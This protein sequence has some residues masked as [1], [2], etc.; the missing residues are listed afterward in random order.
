MQAR[1]AADC[2][3]GSRR[4]AGGYLSGASPPPPPKPLS[5]SLPHICQNRRT[6]KAGLSR[7]PPARSRPGF[8]PCHTVLNT[9]DRNGTLHIQAILSA[10][11]PFAR[12][13]WWTAAAARYRPLPSHTTRSPSPSDF[14]SRIRLRTSHSCRGIWK[15]RLAPWSV[16]NVIRLP[17]SLSLPLSLSVF[18]LPTELLAAE[19]TPQC[20]WLTHARSPASVCVTC[21]SPNSPASK[22]RNCGGVWWLEILY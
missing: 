20:Y 14:E 11:F 21:P 18:S 17:P 15:P 8:L 19:A 3:R 22:Q 1:W 5:L 4:L 12:R 2:H 13:Q 6:D 9:K 16:C 10:A 7:Q